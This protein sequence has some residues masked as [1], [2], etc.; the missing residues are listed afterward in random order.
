MRGG[1]NIRGMEQGE[2]DWICIYVTVQVVHTPSECNSI[3]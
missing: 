1:G 2:G 3:F